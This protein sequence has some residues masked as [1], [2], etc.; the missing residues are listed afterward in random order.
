MVCPKCQKESPGNSK[1][2]VHCGATLAQ[3]PTPPQTAVSEPTTS[4]PQPLNP[5]PTK[6]IL[7]IGIGL[8]LALIAVIAGIGIYFLVIKKPQPS[9]SQPAATPSPTTQYQLTPSPTPT[10]TIPLTIIQTVGTEMPG[11]EAS[12]TKITRGTNVITAN[13][14]FA[15]TGTPQYSPEEEYGYTWIEGRKI[16]DGKQYY[17]DPYDLSSAYLVDDESQMKYEVMKGADG[18]P[19]C[20]IVAA[21]TIKKGES[22]SL[23]AQF[24][25]PP[26][27]TKVVTINL[28]RVQPFVSIP[29]E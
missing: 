18:K 16:E 17:Q 8:G 20:S 24:T 4:T 14:T 21:K 11:I 19:L 9:V 27:T 26:S 23:Y 12:L 5:F 10:P 28:P 13:F 1:F 3:V 2:C 22:I 7:I 15:L 25:A 29:L 6:P